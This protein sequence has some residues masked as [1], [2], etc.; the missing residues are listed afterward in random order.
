MTADLDARAF[1][2]TDV[3]RI[4]P[5][6]RPILLAAFRDRVLALWPASDGVLHISPARTDWAAWLTGR[7]LPWVYDSH[8]LGYEARMATTREGA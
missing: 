6:Q 8:V 4:L 5:A 2:V 3:S 1:S 7:G